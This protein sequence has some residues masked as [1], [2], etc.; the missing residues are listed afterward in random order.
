MRKSATSATVRFNLVFLQPL[1]AG[2][3]VICPGIAHAY[4]GEQFINNVAMYV[5][6]PVA[7]FMI[8]ITLGAAMVKPDIAKHSGYVA[9]VAVV[10]FGVIKLGN[11]IINWM[12]AG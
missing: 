7:F 10:L 11:Q 8:I 9:I 2:S 1:V 4:M 5:I 12:Q 3:V 6:A